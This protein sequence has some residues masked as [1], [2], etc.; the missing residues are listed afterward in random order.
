MK[1]PQ[2]REVPS[3]SRRYTW[4]DAAWT[5]VAFEVESGDPDLPPGI[6]WVMRMADVATRTYHFLYEPTHAI[7]RSITMTPR[8][9]LLTEL[10]WM[11]AELMRTSRSTPEIGGILATLR[12]RYGDETLLDPRTMAADSAGILIDLSKALVASCPEE[13]RAALFNELG[14]SDQQSVMRALAAKKIKPTTATTDGSF[15]QYA[16][17]EILRSLVEGHP[18]F[19][20]DGRIW[21]E[22]YASLDYG[23]KE[24][25]DGARSGIRSKYSGLI[26]DAIWLARQDSSDLAASSREDLIRAMMSLR[27]LRPD[28]ESS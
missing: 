24:I 4:E 18:E 20:F 12:E 2:R 13:E 5:V 25:T 9:G 14:V 22:A 21:D 19:C 15:L 27:L 11:T 1:A 10:S 7:F 17:Y 23:D 3:L 28:V 26:N 6:P 8:D 16:P